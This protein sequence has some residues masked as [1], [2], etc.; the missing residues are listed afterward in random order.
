[1]NNKLISNILWMS[2][3]VTQCLI[4]GVLNSLKYYISE[5]TCTFEMQCTKW[6]HVSQS[7]WCSC[8][9]NLC[10]LTFCLLHC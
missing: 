10:R 8:T 5:K 4:L 2:K 3:K 6:R 7:L 1:M 9:I